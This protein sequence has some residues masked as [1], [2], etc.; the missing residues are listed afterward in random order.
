VSATAR[1]EGHG[2]LLVDA[3]GGVT[4]G[5][6]PHAPTRRTGKGTNLAVYTQT[7]LDTISQRIN[8]TPRRLLHWHTSHD[9]YT[10]AIASIS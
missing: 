7:D 3:Y 8:T 9:H 1:I 5:G 6:A 4:D 10:A 2:A